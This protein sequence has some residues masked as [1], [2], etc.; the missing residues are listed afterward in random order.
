MTA[1]AAETFQD[2][3]CGL[4]PL[5]SATAQ[6]VGSPIPEQGAGDRDAMLR[7]VGFC[8]EWTADVLDTVNRDGT[9][10]MSASLRTWAGGVEDEAEASRAHGLLE[11]TDSALRRVRSSDIGSYAAGA[12]H[13]ASQGDVASTA[14]QTAQT[15]YERIDT[16]SLEVVQR[17]ALRVLAE[18]AAMR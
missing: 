12:A 5:G 14:A 16:D 8:C 2:T 11:A 10:G 6:A 13:A 3:L 18:L 15:L 1:T 4:L 9:D 17:E 7:L